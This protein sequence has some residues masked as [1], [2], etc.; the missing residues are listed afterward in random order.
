[1]AVA[2]AAATGQNAGQAGASVSL[3]RPSDDVRHPDSQTEWWYVHAVDPQSGRVVVLSFFTAPLPAAGGFLYT[4]AGKSH[5]TRLSEEEPHSGP[6]VSLRDGGV[7]FDS[8]SGSWI[9]EQQAGG[10]EVYLELTETRP[11]VTAGPLEFGSE[12]MYWTIPVA[13]GSANGWITDQEGERTEV[14]EWR[15]YH[16]HNWGAFEL[17][18]TQSDGWEWAAVHE[19]AGRASILGGINQLEGDFSGVLLRV[20]PSQTTWCTPNLEKDA[21]ITVDGFSY[22]QTIEA[23]CDEER[24]RFSV[25]EPYVVPLSTHALSES[26]GKTDVE[27]SLGLIEHLAALEESP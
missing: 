27:G 11:G 14:R 22:P 9:V 21:W 3:A 1:M 20:T 18:S 5:W 24:V 13:T 7:R 16:D 17:Q 10:Y 25:T 8:S 26:V 15:A 19:T 12:Q 4:E 6:G 2:Q 23:S